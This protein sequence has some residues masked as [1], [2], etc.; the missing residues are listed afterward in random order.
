MSLI[1]RA[2]ALNRFVEA[3][4]DNQVVIMAC[5]TI[6]GFFGRVPHTENAIRQIKGRGETKPFLILLADASDLTRVGVRQIEDPI[7]SLWPGP[8]T[9][10]FPTLDSGTVA[11]RVPANPD[12]RDMIRQVGF[13]LYSTSVNRSGE[14]SIND[15]QKI[16]AEF[17]KEVAYVED[18]GVLTDCSPST[19]VDLTQHPRKILRQGRGQVPSK[20]LSPA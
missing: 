4:K 20:Y 5:D 14:N 2:R 8:F 6:Y 19:I 18:A 1:H 10:I 7:L 17:G 15:S 13:P 9:F 11:C 12:L 16:Y 3:L